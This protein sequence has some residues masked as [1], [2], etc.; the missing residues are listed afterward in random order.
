MSLFILTGE[1]SGDQLAS[2]L[3]VRIKQSRPELEIYGVCGPKMRALQ[4]VELGAMEKF[5]TF[6]VSPR[7]FFESRKVRNA[8]LKLNPAVCVFIDA[9]YFSFKMASWL[10]QSGYQGKIIK[11]VCP[12]TWWP[13]HG[14]KQKLEKLFDALISIFPHEQA[15]FEGSK[16]P[17]YYVGHALLERGLPAEVLAQVGEGSLAL[18]PG[19]RQIEIKWGIGKLLKACVLFQETYPEVLIEVSCAASY[20][21][22]GIEQAVKKHLKARIAIIDTQQDLEKNALLARARVALAKPGTINLELAK[23]A[24]P[25]LI[26]YPLPAWVR[27]CLKPMCSMINYVAGKEV[28]PELLINKPYLA[29]NAASILESL[30][31]DASERTQIKMTCVELT[32]RLK[33]PELSKDAAEIVLDAL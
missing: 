26:A 9:S 12:A 8:I 20:L 1:N 29:Q 6:F 23:Y 32:Q 16:L 17:V 13:D 22:P 31:F 14:R 3:I 11:Y 21:R 7:L 28:F 2:E 18:F 10:R 25:T 5:Q 19:S 15:C 24:V 27:W 33:K 4:V 30:W